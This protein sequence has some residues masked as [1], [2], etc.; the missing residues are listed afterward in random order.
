MTDKVEFE[1]YEPRKQLYVLV[2]KGKRWCSDTTDKWMVLDD[3]S[4]EEPDEET[5]ILFQKVIWR[6][7]F[8]ERLR[9]HMMPAQVNYADENPQV[10]E[11][12]KMINGRA[13]QLT[14]AAAP[15]PFPT[16]SQYVASTSYTKKA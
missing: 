1:V 2:Y 3:D 8:S 6:Y 11:L 12:V 5:T 4:Y 16:T 9:Q 13:A 7:Q 10:E 15:L 14:A